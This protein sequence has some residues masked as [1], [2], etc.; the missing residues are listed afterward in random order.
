[1][2]YTRLICFSVIIFWFFAFILSQAYVEPSP[3]MFTLVQASAAGIAGMLAGDK[4]SK[5]G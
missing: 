4:G 2:F 3:L 1:M 5:N